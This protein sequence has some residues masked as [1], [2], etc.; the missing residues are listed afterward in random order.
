MK[1][2]KVTF[3]TNT[4]DCAARPECH[5]KDS[6]QPHFVKVHDAMKAGRLKGYF[7]ETLVTLEG[8]KN[9]DRVDVL[10]DT[11]LD[12]QIRS[13]GQNTISV[14]L[15]VQQ[16]RKP[17][18]PKHAARIQAALKVGMRALRAPSR[19][20]WTLIE[21]AI[22]SFF[23]HDAEAKFADPMGRTNDAC[24]AIEARGV[25]FAL[26]KSLATSFAKRDRAEIAKQ[27]E[28]EFAKLDE[29]LAPAG[30][31]APRIAF[32]EPWFRSLLRAKDIH[33]KRKVQRAVA[34]WADADSIAAHIGYGSDLSCTE[35]QGKDAGSPSFLTPTI[36][37][38]WRRPTR[39]NS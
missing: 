31:R 18:H 11:R 15:T 27:Q 14:D 36:A 26:I 9:A 28:E 35:D 25:G 30:L 33:E 20:R 3:D 1:W 34:E 17:L 22:G 7:S 23:A 37:P 4:L 6:G 10:G 39:S 8:I 24:A 21:D 13:T 19:A 2:M 5:L 38:G 29:M 32:E 12:R 16:A